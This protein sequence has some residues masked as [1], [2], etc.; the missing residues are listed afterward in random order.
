MPPKKTFKVSESD[1]TTTNTGAPPDAPINPAVDPSKTAEE[2]LD[3][4]REQH[5]EMQR[6]ADLGIPPEA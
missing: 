4:L 3:A 6:R 1:A 2:R 5:A